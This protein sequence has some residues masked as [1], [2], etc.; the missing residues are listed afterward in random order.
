MFIQEIKMETKIINLK[1][2]DI[3][4]EKD[5]R[6]VHPNKIH[7]IMSLCAKMSEINV[8]IIDYCKISVEEV[9]KMWE[10]SRKLSNK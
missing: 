1:I 5:I 6:Q 9:K 7:N 10:V 2:G 3:P 4:T 8:R